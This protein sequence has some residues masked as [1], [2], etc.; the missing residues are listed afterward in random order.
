MKITVDLPDD[1]V[2]A[3]NA[4]AAAEGREF[5][6]VVVEAIRISLGLQLPPG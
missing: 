2:I 3:I 4:K 5:N 6:E 1:L